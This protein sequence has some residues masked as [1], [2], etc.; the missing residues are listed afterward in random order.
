MAT[1]ADYATVEAP[2]HVPADRIV[3]FDYL[4]PAGIEESDVYTALRPLHDLPDI[5]WTPRNG[6]H[7]ILT[8]SDD[9]KWAREEHETFSHEEFGVPRGA[10]NVFMPPVTVDPPRH[11]RYRAVLNP[12][13]S[14]SSARA[15]R[16]YA[17][18][19]AAG[20][21]DALLPAG[22]CEF[23]MDFARIMPVTVF[24]KMLGLSTE[25]RDEFVQW[26]VGYTSAKDQETKDRSADAVAAF[27]AGELDAREADP[28]ED[29][30]SRIVAFRKNPRFEGEFEVMG[31]AMVSFIGGLDTLSNMMSFT[32]WHLA[33]HPELRRRLV[34]EPELVVPAAEEFIR[35][36]GLTMTGRLIKRDVTRKGVSMKA[37]EMALV[38]DPLAGLDERAWPDPL[39]IRPERACGDHDTFGNSAH[40]CVGEHLA[41]V[42]LIVFIEEW[43]KRIPDF[44]LDPDVPPVSYSGPVIGMTQLGLTW[45][46]SPQ[47]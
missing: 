39:E 5:L 11:A 28:G 6:G 7:W 24:L 40:K 13:F 1:Q 34:R 16:D 23:V 2:A 14:P 29:L 4:V 3:D 31:M 17:R 30:L 38:V 37:G 18:E 10:M 19:V 8:R 22:K 27:L 25:R 44:A 26:A 33:V 43:L 47:R 32:A 12:A 36:F 35:R 45:G 42:E 46:N 21:V 15:M 20:L 9:I 41:R